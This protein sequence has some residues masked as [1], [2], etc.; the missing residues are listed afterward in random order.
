MEGRR[1]VVLNRFQYRTV[2]R[3]LTLVCENHHA[4]CELRIPPWFLV[5]LPYAKLLLAFYLL[6]GLSRSRI[7][8]SSLLF[9]WVQTKLFSQGAVIPGCTKLY[10]S[11]LEYRRL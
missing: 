6:V 5:L 10:M 8:R 7:I 1:L 2:L 4:E 9:C 11:G 3:Y